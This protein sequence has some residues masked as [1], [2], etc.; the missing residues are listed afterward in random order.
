MT[1][2]TGRCVRKF[3]VL[4]PDQKPCPS[5]GCGEGQECR[6]FAR[7]GGKVCVSKDN[8][9]K[10]GESCSTQ[11]GVNDCLAGFDCKTNNGQPYLGTC[12]K[13]A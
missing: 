8:L 11:S 13:K 3:A 2:S 5:E 7:N 4:A 10:E 9:A 6:P 12:V 1:R